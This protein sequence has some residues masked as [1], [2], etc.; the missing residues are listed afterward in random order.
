MGF[1]GFPL[2][3]FCNSPG[4]FGWIFNMAR[5]NLGGVRKIKHNAVFKVA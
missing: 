1:P 3:M 5:L 4:L 2:C